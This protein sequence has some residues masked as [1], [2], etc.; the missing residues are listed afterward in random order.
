VSFV[1]ALGTGV[2]DQP[3]EV[4]KVGKKTTKRTQGEGKRPE[5]ER[6]RPKRTKVPLGTELEPWLSEALD[7]AA[8]REQR[9]KTVLVSRA[10][11]LYLSQ[12]HPDLIPPDKAPPAKGD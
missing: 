12:E 3:R 7:I 11:V 10:L 2:L 6:K 9:K 8:Q 4:T 5:G 1:D